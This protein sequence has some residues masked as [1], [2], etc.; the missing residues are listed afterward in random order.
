VNLADLLVSLA[1]MGLVLTATLGVLRQG[2]QVY[3]YGT[4][5][6]EAQQAARVALQRMATEIRQ[7]GF[8]AHDAAFDAV[9]V[10]EPSRIVLQFDVNGD[11]V[12]AGNGETITWLLANGVLRRNAGG[13]AQPIVNGVRE[14]RFAYVDAALQPTTVAADVRG[15]GIVLATVPE[16][17]AAAVPVTARVATFVRLRNR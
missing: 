6:V 1:C 17:A 4:A 11:G 10:A 9:T 14:L 5:R 12:I 2:Q 16:H 8:G 13:G 7:A 15:V 3:A